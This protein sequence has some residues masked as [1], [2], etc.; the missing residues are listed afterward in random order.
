[1]DVLRSFSNPLN[2]S[3]VTGMS[4]NVLTVTFDGQFMALAHI[5]LTTQNKRR[6]PGPCMAGVHRECY[7][8]LTT[9]NLLIFQV[10]RQP[11]QP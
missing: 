1:M 4:F 10:R 6:C 3:C 9:N 7:S 5:S 8:T 2:H 11:C